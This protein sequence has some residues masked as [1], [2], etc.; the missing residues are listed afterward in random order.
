[1]QAE[2]GVDLVTIGARS[3]KQVSCVKGSK[4]PEPVFWI[5]YWESLHESGPIQMYFMTPMLNLD[6]V[7]VSFNL[8]KHEMQLSGFISIGLMVE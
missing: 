6:F 1:M 8:L 4:A 7:Q 3:G 5:G 2:S